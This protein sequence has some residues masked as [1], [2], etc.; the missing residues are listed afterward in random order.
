VDGGGTLWHKL[1]YPRNARVTIRIPNGSAIGLSM[2]LFA[3]DQMADWRYQDAPAIGS[4]SGDDSFDALSWTGKTG[5]G[6]YIYVQISY[7]NPWTVT[8]RVNAAISP[9]KLRI[10]DNGWAGTKP[11]CLSLF[12]LEP[13]S[14]AA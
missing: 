9:G 14:C 6:E 8:F 13:V 10:G 7:R 12:V 11:P 5:N 1:A 3:S 4:A 2:T